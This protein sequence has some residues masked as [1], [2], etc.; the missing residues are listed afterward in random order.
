MKIKTH[1]TKRYIISDEDENILRRAAKLF[2]ELY[3]CREEH[4]KYESDFERA[5]D[6]IDYLIDQLK[7]DDMET[8]WEENYTSIDEP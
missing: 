7:Q 1:S 5:R 6:D 8:F 3:D 2:D 4:G